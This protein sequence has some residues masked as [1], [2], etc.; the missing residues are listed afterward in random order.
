MTETLKAEVTE[1]RILAH[2]LE[3]FKNYVEYDLFQDWSLPIYESETNAHITAFYQRN[4][5]EVL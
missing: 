4:P 5:T 1:I 2:D 3:H